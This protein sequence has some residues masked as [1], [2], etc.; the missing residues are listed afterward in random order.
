MK[1]LV[2][3]M[4]KSVLIKDTG[5]AALQKTER[6]PFNHKPDTH[7]LSR[8]TASTERGNNS[9]ALASSPGLPARA[10]ISAKRGGGFFLMLTLGTVWRL[11]LFSIA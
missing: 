3:I 8:T 2:F 4:I 10:V 6:T 1:D 7:T 5:L 9:Q 11:Q